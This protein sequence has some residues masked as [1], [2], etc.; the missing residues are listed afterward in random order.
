MSTCKAQCQEPPGYWHT[1]T[2][3]RRSVTE[4]EGLPLCKQHATKAD[5]SSFYIAEWKRG[6]R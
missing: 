3:G 1:H 4:R 5:K 6:P 2:C